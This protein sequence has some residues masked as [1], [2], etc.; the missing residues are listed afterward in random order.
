MQG[1]TPRRRHA[2]NAAFTA[3]GDSERAMCISKL[4][5]YYTGGN[6]GIKRGH[7]KLSRTEHIM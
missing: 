7:V 5:L 1:R 4:R 2:R 3:Q 6:H